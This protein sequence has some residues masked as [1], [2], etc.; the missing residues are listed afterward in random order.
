MECGA[1]SADALHGDWQTAEKSKLIDYRA[2]AGWDIQ[3]RV[4]EAVAGGLK[5]L[6]Q[7]FFSTTLTCVMSR[8]NHRNHHWVIR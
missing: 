8:Q 6:L 5:K 3:R 4:K 1:R 7:S 2:Y